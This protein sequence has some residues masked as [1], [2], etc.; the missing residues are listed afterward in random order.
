MKTLFEYARERQTL[1]TIFAV[2][3]IVLGGVQ[4]VD[5][6]EVWW[7]P[8]T[9]LL[10]IL[11][12]IL[13]FIYARVVI[14][15]ILSVVIM[16]FGAYFGFFV[17]EVEFP[18]IGTIGMLWAV[19]MSLIYLFNLAIS[20]LM[21]SIRS[22][23]TMIS[24]S[25]IIQFFSVFFFLGTGMEPRL[26]IAIGAVLGALVF[27][28]LYKLPTELAYRNSKMPE[29]IA[30]DVLTDTLR[31]AF[32]SAG[33]TFR[34]IRL[35]GN[36]GGYLVVKDR[37]YYLH[38]VKMFSDFQE[39]RKTQLRYS[40]KPIHKWLTAIIHK[41]IPVLRSKNA[42]IMPVLLDINNANGSLGKVVG[43]SVADSRRDTPFGIFPGRELN[44]SRKDKSPIITNFEERFGG[45][46]YPVEEKHVKSIS[47]IGSRD[48]SNKGSDISADG[49]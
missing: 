39:Y 20:Y 46:A 19:S 6:P 13:T 35:K 4:M 25:S 45:F 14:K 24:F 27:L 33:W 17:G 22:R 15:G 8:P 23:W 32:E 10:S 47:S 1:L 40:N 42:P 29:N 48:L 37:A 43:V 38:P 2:L 36:K 3:A 7:V 12:L 34:D 26:S 44:S 31:D 28:A 30:S 41:R 5:N 16:S 49:G 9:V 18:Q 11:A 21:S